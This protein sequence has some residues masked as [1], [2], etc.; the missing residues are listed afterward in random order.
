V[1]PGPE[2]LIDRNP[3]VIEAIS[4]P[5]APYYVYLLVDPGSG[6]PF[7]V[8]KGRGER[9][10][11]HGIEAAVL[12]TRAASGEEQRRKIARIQ[13]IR[14][15]GREPRIEFARIRIPTEREAFLVEAALIDVLDRHGD[16]LVNEVRGHDTGSG[17]VTL[18]DL[19]RSHG[20]TEF[21]TTERA[22][23]INLGRWR[24]DPDPDVPR[25][26]HG[27]RPD[28]TADELY[29]STRAWWRIGRREYP[30]AV[31]VH[32]GITRAVW[33]IDPGSWVSHQ[34]EGERL[35]WAFEGGPAPAD[36]HD[37]FV[38]AIGRRVPA[39]RPDDRVVFG[40]QGA[41]AYWPR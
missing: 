29:A 32:E 41:I 24:A 22:I 25:S 8:G 37:A 12:S 1:N 26:G 5:D 33:A 39:R 34:R 23:L 2:R 13:A 11:S 10:A 16:P 31:A 21:T 20:T 9:F 38:G 17:L 28:M 3:L 4:S 36:I 15:S 30:Y 18:E 35:R 14:A 6:R 7:Y 40:R 19:E 27:Y